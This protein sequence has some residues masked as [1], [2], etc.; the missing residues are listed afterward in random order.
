MMI[1]YISCGFSVIFFL[2]FD[3]AENVLARFKRF[4]QCIV[5]HNLWFLDCL[6]VEWKWRYRS[7]VSVYLS[8]WPWPFNAS[9]THLFISRYFFSFVPSLNLILFS[10]FFRCT[11]HFLYLFFLHHI[12]FIILLLSTLP[13]YILLCW[14]ILMSLG[15]SSSSEST[16][17]L[18]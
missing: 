5:N 14:H 15:D 3:F 1:V 13:S 2:S 16:K 17:T 18:E 12:F 8:M 4:L 7:C 11:F 9:H 10:L 6:R